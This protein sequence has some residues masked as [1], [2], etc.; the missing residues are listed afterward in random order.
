MNFKI[1][2]VILSVILAASYFAYTILNAPPPPV[3]VQTA[4]PISPYYITVIRASWGLNCLEKANN[5]SENTS[6]QPYAD[7]STP[8]KEDNVLLRVSAI[9]NGKP[10]CQIPLNSNALGA[11]PMPN[12]SKTLQVDYRCFAVDRL[13]I[14]KADSGVLGI[15]CETPFKEQR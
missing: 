8:I 1:H 2:L 14:G 9:C 15:D 4:A 12:C 6:P 13:R 11:D 3:A 7:N 5:Y 10:T